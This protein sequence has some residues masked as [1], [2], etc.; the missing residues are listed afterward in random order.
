M[1]K[2]NKRLLAQSETDPLTGMANRRKLNIQA[3]D[4]FMNAFEAGHNFAI[5]ILDVD[6]FKV[7]Q[8]RIKEEMFNQKDM[9]G[10]DG[11]E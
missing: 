7:A 1:E 11:T 5:E 3:D 8:R 10:Y 9:F 2:E 4:M 6:Y